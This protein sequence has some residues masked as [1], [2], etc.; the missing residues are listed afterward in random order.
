MKYNATFSSKRTNIR[1]LLSAFFLCI[2]LQGNLFAQAPNR[3]S[4]QAVMTDT[5][6]L[7]ILNSPVGIK[8]S[9]LQGTPV[10][11]AV[12]I[13]T[14]TTTTNG[15]G[16]ISLQIGDGTPVS[17]TIAGIDWSMGP[18][19]V[20]TE[21]DPTGG[22]SYSIIGTSELLSVPYALY[23]VN[24]TPGPAGPTGAPGPAGPSGPA[25]PTGASGPAGPQGAAGVQGPAGPQGATG[26]QGNVGPAGPA[27]PQGAAGPQGPQGATGPQGPTG[28]VGPAGA[29]GPQGPQ[30]PQGATG[31]VLAQ[32]FNGFI[33][34]IAAGSAEYVFAG[35]TTT[36]TITAGQ[37]LI[38]AASAPLA[39]G[40]GLTT[41]ARIGLCYANSLTPTALINFVGG[42]YSIVEVD[43]TRDTYSSVGLTFGLPAGTYIVGLGVYNSGANPINNND[44]V[45]GWVMVLN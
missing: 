7:P 25:G 32:N 24:G 38:G 44:Y 39:T 5:A 35:T 41:Q 28:A 2:L 12:L 16:L 37:K 22:T 6:D 29:A 34:A 14:H 15:N 8:I 10:G 27:G 42:Q 45:N 33:P 1:L 40:A 9:I 20:K 26:P 36:V 17:G 13:E 3:I 19:F 11:P 18:Y 31:V 21:T 4:Y 30:G 43:P 23:S